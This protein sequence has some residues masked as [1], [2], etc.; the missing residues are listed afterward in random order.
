[1]RNLLAFIRK[2]NRRW[3]LGLITIGLVMLIAS[4]LA[5]SVPGWRTREA[6]QIAVI[7]SGV[8]ATAWLFRW[9]GDDSHHV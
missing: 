2:G 9:K 6:V 4:H 5:E 8:A 3:S 1:M 7:L